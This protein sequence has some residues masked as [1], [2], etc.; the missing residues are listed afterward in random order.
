M[1]ATSIPLHELIGDNSAAVVLDL[2]AGLIT[3]ALGRRVE[4]LH[5]AEVV[6]GQEA[7]VN[8]ML[9]RDLPPHPLIVNRRERFQVDFVQQLPVQRELQFLVFRLESRFGTSG[10]LQQPLLPG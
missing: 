7:R 10:I 6:I 3:A 2:M 4:T 5:P 9:H 1:P 8:L